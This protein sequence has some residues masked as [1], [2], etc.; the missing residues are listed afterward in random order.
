LYEMLT[1]HLPFTSDTPV[2]FLIHHMQTAP[3]PPQALR[4]AVHLPES[5]TA[6]LMRALEKNRDRR[7]QTAEEFIA[8]MNKPHVVAAATA[9]LGSDAL[10]AP[11]ATTR[12]HATPSASAARAGL[13]PAGPSVPPPP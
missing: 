9:V 5:V 2:G 13:A 11:I 8:A 10:G 6:V 7:F 1:G 3:T 4:P 12:R